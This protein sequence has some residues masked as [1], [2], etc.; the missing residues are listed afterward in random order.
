MTYLSNKLEIV[1]ELCYGIRCYYMFLQG[2][3]ELL[4]I[5]YHSTILYNEETAA[6]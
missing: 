4:E 1:I 5:G 2:S 6:V 3:P